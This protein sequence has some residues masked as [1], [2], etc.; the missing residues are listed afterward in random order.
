MGAVA[1]GGHCV[2]RHEGRVVFVR[3]TLPGELVTVRV[4]DTGHDRFWRGDAVEVHEAAPER[5]E[6]PCPVSGPG[7]CGGCDFQH[8]S[9]DGQ[10]ALKTAVVAE[11]LQRLAGLSWDGA[12]EAA[13][14]D[15]GGL[16]W[17]TRMRYHA[18]DDG[19]LALRRH[20]D[21]AL[22]PVPA[23]GCPISDPRGRPER[24]GWTRG[25]VVETAVDSAGTRTTLVDGDRVEGPA[26]L[27]QEVDG[28]SLA[29]AAD[30]FWQVHPGA[31]ATL[32]EA[33]LEGLEPQP[34]ERAFDLYCGVGLFAVALARRGL[35]VWG[36]ESSRSAVAH[37]RRNLEAVG[38]EGSRATAGRVAQVL[39]RM[40]GRTDLVVLDPPR[41][42]AGPEV[43]RA[44]L[45]RR[46]RRIAY[47]A[48]D[49]AALARDLRTAVDGGY[50][51]VS[52][53][54]F[55]LFPMTHHVECV[56]VLERTGSDARSSGSR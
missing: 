38:A 35:Q 2:A 27:H 20:R 24:T 42:G 14:G 28:S 39:R 55:D 43:V 52:L 17:R 34:G 1:H 48:C 32:V 56:A 40:P 16:G 33:V 50:E 22:Q 53:R 12:V 46:P 4:T 54:G 8:V 19:V 3:H 31:A 7:R 44:V 13:P 36:V 49:P 9:L 5:T 45:A 30:G 25:A 15:V 29:V 41:T 18:D 21:H 11:Q 6:A 37:A 26:L 47:V 23:Q 51:L 10:R